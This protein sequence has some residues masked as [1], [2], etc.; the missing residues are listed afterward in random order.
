MFGII[1][2]SKPTSVAVGKESLGV[3]GVITAKFVLSIITKML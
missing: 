1:F 3:M 2:R